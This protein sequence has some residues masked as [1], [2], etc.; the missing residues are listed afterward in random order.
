MLLLLIETMR[1]MAGMIGGE[2]HERCLVPILMAFC[3][4]DERTVSEA[5]LNALMC[6][7]RRMD[8]KKNEDFVT[9]VIKKLVESDSIGSK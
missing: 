7:I 9:D 4:S 2:Q 5:A 6:I 8:L 3:R 1:D